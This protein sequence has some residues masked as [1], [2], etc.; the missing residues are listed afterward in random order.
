MIVEKNN[1]NNPDNIFILNEKL[2]QHIEFEHMRMDRIESKLDK[3]TEIIISLSRVEEKIV[4]L[5]D[6]SKDLKKE[7]KLSKDQIDKLNFQVSKNTSEIE[8]I[9]K[10]KWIIFTSLSTSFFAALTAII[11]NTKFI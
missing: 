8:A 4:N 5:I 9:K 10:I 2:D 11:I 1:K 6:D 3:I 7:L